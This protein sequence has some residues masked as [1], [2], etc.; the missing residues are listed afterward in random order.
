MTTSLT[1]TTA[2]EDK[3]PT[4]EEKIGRIKQIYDLIEAKKVS[5]TD[6]IPLLE[7]VYKLKKEVEV[8][9]TEIENKLITLSDNDL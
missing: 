3:Y 8:I 5:L 7:E 1:K 4:L 6:S 9:L 2:L